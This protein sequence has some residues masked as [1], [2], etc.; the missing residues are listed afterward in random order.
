MFGIWRNPVT[1]RPGKISGLACGLC[2]LVLNQAI[3]DEYFCTPEHAAGFSYDE[4]IKDWKDIKYPATTYYTIT[5]IRFGKHAYVVKQLGNPDPLVFCQAGFSSAG[6]LL[7]QRHHINFK[8]SKK[9][10]K[11]I[12]FSSGE[13]LNEERVSGF[14]GPWM[15]IGKCTQY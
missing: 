8:F 15:Q 5:P 2:A 3:A 7:C 4:S 10:G 11:Y 13:Y 14:R 9:T 6:Y 1:A 12:M